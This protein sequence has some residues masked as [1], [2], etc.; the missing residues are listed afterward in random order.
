MNKRVTTSIILAYCVIG[1]PSHNQ[2]KLNLNMSLSHNLP[3]TIILECSFE[4]LLL[5]M[6]HWEEVGLERCNQ[7][8]YFKDTAGNVFHV[9]QSNI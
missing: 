5:G 3:L 7:Y 4:V 8:A 1:L 9:L 2:I 6:G